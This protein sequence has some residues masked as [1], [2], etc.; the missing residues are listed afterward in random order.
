[1]YNVLWTDCSTEL[2]GVYMLIKVDNLVKNIGEP[3]CC[4]RYIKLPGGVCVDDSAF[5]R[6]DGY[7][8]NTDDGKYSF[9][10]KVNAELTLVCDSCLESFNYEA[11]FD[12]EEVYT[13]RESS[14]EDEMHFT[15]KTIDLEP[16]VT[17]SVLL[18]L[19][20]KAMCCENCRGLCRVCG[21]NLNEG[22]CGCDRADVD[23][24][25]E[26]LRRF[27]NDKEV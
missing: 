10:G 23:P 3:V 6:V 27:I 24:R 4:E 12:M 16:A 8:A 17:E 11:C 7:V 26:M 13:R 21:H 22:E 14:E 20:M 9:K 2:R 18:N 25:L 5:V 19:P 15:G 1:M